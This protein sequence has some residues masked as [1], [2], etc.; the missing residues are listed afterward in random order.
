MAFCWKLNHIKNPSLGGRGGGGY[1][2]GVLLETQPHKKPSIGGG[3]G[4]GEDEHGVLLE[5]QP[6]KKPSIGGGGRIRAW[7]FVGNSTT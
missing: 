6:H 7:R 2:H 5:T 1:E 3:G 4:G